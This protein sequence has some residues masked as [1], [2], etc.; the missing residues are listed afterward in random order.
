MANSSDSS[1]FIVF[2]DVSQ[3]FVVMTER[4]NHNGTQQRWKHRKQHR[5]AKRLLMLHQLY[6][7]IKRAESW[8]RFLFQVHHVACST[9]SWKWEILFRSRQEKKLKLLT[10]MTSWVADFT[11]N[12]LKA[13]WKFSRKSLIS[14]NRDQASFKIAFES[15]NLQTAQLTSAP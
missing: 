5:I 1:A 10:I 11:P 8:C 9:T 3:K 2:V 14:G 12:V 4:Q 13:S 15:A 6:A 7:I